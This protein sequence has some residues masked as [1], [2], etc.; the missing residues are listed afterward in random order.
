[1]PGGRLSFAP[2]RDAIE[3]SLEKEF[4]AGGWIVGTPD[5]SIYLN[6]DLIKEKK[7][8]RE[9]VAKVAAE[10]AL[11]TPHIFRVYTR[12]QLLNGYVMGDQIGRR[13]MR[14]YSARRGADLYLLLEPYYIFGKLS[15][16]HGS[17]FGYDTHVPVIFMGPGIKAGKYHSSIAI[18]DIAPTLATIL[19]VE[20]PSGS[21]GRILSEMFSMP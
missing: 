3:M 21:E 1:M 13:L 2:I 17:A 4:G 6:W 11:A 12:E 16:T 20:I 9:E 7:L 19:E 14:S 8:A 10:A 5:E 15:T 18:N